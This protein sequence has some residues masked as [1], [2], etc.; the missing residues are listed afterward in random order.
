[1]CA[2]HTGSHRLATR[3]VVLVPEDPPNAPTTQVAILWSGSVGVPEA[4][5]RNVRL[6]V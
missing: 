4:V 2:R 3:P 1:M 6:G 5:C